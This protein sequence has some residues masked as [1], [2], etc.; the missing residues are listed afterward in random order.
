MF[1]YQV[2]LV[3]LVVGLGATWITTLLITK[4]G[5]L[6][7]A[8][9]SLG[10]CP[11]KGILLLHPFRNAAIV[12]GPIFPFKGM[13]G[14]YFGKFSQYRK[15]G[16]TCL[17]S[18]VL[19]DLRP[20]VWTADPEVFRV[21]S[22]DRPTFIKDVEAYEPLNIYGPNI[23]GTEG[24]EWKRHRDIARS[25]FN[26]KNNNIVWEE[27]I[28]I[29]NEWFDAELAGKADGETINL[30]PAFTN[31]AL[32]VI[33]SAGFGRRTPWTAASSDP[34]LVSYHSM[35][36]AM[37]LKTT[38]HCLFVKALTPTPM[39]ALS[40]KIYIPW[41]SSVLNDTTNAFESLRKHM[42][43]IISDARAA[44]TTESRQNIGYPARQ[45]TTGYKIQSGLLANLVEANTFSGEDNFTGDK[46]R[47][48]TDEELLSDTFIFLLAGHETSAHSLCFAALLL[49]L[50]PEVQAKVLREVTTL[51]PNGAPTSNSFTT[52]KE[53]ITKLDYTSAVIQEAIRMFPP[54]M[55]LGKLASAD[56][57]VKSKIFDSHSLKILREIDVPI[58][59]GSVVVL[60]VLGLHMNPLIWGD[61]VE[62]C[63][64]ERF[65]DTEGYR[66]PREA[67]AGFSLGPRNCIG[68]RFALSEMVCVLALLIR[69][70]EVLVPVSL[71]GK[72]MEEKKSN[73]LD[74]IPGPTIIPANA[75]VRLKERSH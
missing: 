36:F 31:V 6:R 21:A 19:W 48:L 66:W 58:K 17:S 1:A 26:E 54:V 20:V 2:S 32:L 25:A 28:R 38:I 42:L 56:T 55:R 64:P 70:W 40:H 29:V 69:K 49:A 46:G 57:H 61:D 33:A 63:K 30:L 67:F 71:E 47:T 24:A 27:S 75:G 65:I 7:S 43:E 50:Y 51:W 41:L 34:E 22:L 45:E 68:Q 39:Y 12:A 11:G 14:Y 74:W 4:S 16:S 44:G 3:Q 18:V 13:I 52:F 72:T 73:M 60:D 8:L 35:N 53:S 37:A 15:Y 9:K 5:S 59:A 62:D 10:N 23:V